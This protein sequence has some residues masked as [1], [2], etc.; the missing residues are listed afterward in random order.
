MLDKTEFV[1]DEKN[2]N[3]SIIFRGKK[4][5]NVNDNNEPELFTKKNKKYVDEFN[6]YMKKAKKE[7]EK[8]PRA[9]IQ[10]R[11]GA[12]DNE[13]NEEIF[14]ETITND[15]ILEIQNKIDNIIDENNL[16]KF[17]DNDQDP[18]QTLF[19]RN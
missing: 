8:T 6:D 10:E 7:Y 19:E 1:F 3:Y 18:R 12:E 5:G 13:T 2:K 9:A 11:I 4:I 15:S 16:K 17:I 14:Y